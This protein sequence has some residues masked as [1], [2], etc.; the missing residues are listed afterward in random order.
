[1]ENFFTTTG[2]WSG[3]T[4]DELDRVVAVYGSDSENK[5][6]K[7]RGRTY[8]WKDGGFHCRWYDDP[9]SLKDLEEDRASL[10]APLLEYFKKLG[11]YLGYEVED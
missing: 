2:F 5:H 11:D 7:I 3:L 1:M 4:L 8:W 10:R 6:F 9:L